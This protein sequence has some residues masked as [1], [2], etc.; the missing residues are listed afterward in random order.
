MWTWVQLAKING[1]ISYYYTCRT[2]FD[3]GKQWHIALSQLHM[4]LSH[5][6]AGV[7]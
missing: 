5:T 1:R 6:P 2:N 4:F 3:K 7:R